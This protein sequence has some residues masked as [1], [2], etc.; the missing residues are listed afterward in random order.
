MQDHYTNCAGC[1]NTCGQDY[2][3]KPEVW[4][5]SG[6]GYHDGV[7]HLACLAKK[8][9]RPLTIDDFETHK[10]FFTVNATFFLGVELGKELA[11]RKKD[12][13]ES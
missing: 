9:G 13:N 1:G 5:A 7:L 8:L 4:E 2:M 6:T 3:V 12:E 11:R 10:C